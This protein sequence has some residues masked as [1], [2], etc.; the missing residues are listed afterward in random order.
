MAEVLVDFDSEFNGPDHRLYK[1][2]ACSR[3]RPDGLWDAWL[4]FAPLDGSHVIQTGRETT[5]P[6]RETVLYWATGLTTTYIEGALERTL[7]PPLPNLSDREVRATPAYEA[8]APPAAKPVLDPFHVYAEGEAVLRG[9]L[10][11]LDESQLRTIARAYG[12]AN[13]KQLDVANRGELISLIMLA[14][15]KRVA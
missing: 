7:A 5:Q 2:Q 11:A 15:E 9:Q 6:N 10:N 14:A 3:E 13:A 4:E 8:P 1:A 12:I